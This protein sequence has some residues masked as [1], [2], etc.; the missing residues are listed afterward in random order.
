M[1]HSDK[2]SKRG[3]DREILEEGDSES[4]VTKRVY[5]SVTKEDIL[6]NWLHGQ[7]DKSQQSNNFQNKI[8]LFQET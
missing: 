1:L 4:V 8:W 6:N 2:I 3:P 7:A 5:K